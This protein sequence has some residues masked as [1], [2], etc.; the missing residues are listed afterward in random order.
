MT[1]AAPR[2]RKRRPAARR[3]KPSRRANYGWLQWWPVV[4]GIIIAPFAVR[5]VDILTLTGPWG[6]RFLVP[7]TFLLHG[8]NFHLPEVWADHLIEGVMYAQF[9]FYGLIAMLLHRKFRWST[10]VAIL[11]ALH[12]AGFLALAAV[13]GS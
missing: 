10:T 12:L 13:E 5:A 7:W 6:A 1:N 11:V 9:P 2:S 4:L 8:H 3:A